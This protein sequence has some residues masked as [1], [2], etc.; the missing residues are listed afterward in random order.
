MT[1]ITLTNPEKKYDTMLSYFCEDYYH[2]PYDDIFSY[3]SMINKKAHILELEYNNNCDKSSSKI[4]KPHNIWSIRNVGSNLDNKNINNVEIRNSYKIIE[5]I[6]SCDKDKYIKLRNE[7]DEFY[8]YLYEDNYTENNKISSSEY[9]TNQI[10]SF[11]KYLVDNF[12]SSYRNEALYN[13]IHYDY[14][15]KVSHYNSLRKWKVHKYEKGCF[16]KPHKDTKINELHI[17][18]VVLI[19]PKNYSPYTGGNLII[20]DSKDQNKKILDITPIDGWQSVFIKLDQKHEILEVTSGTRYSFTSPFCISKVTVDNIS[21]IKYNNKIP[22]DIVLEQKK[23]S[24]EEEIEKNIKTLEDEIKKLTKKKEVLLCK[25]RDCDIDSEL[26][27]KGQITYQEIANKKRFMVICE[28]FYSNPQPD[29]LNTLDIDIYNS[30]FD[31]PE[32]IEGKPEVHFINTQFTLFSG[33]SDHYKGDC[34]SESEEFWG[35]E[36]GNS[37][38]SCEDNK[39]KFDKNMIHTHMFSELKKNKER[40]NYGQYDDTFCY[41]YSYKT[42]G[43]YVETESEYNDNYYENSNHYNVTC[44]IVEFI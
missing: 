1:S 28:G 5:H 42:P 22:Y 35:F 21:N 14:S 25:L 26:G 32:N 10:N 44:M 23:S 6:D 31:Y 39:L 34:E 16:F 43:R 4:I 17:G 37:Y 27:E 36:D 20:Y 12:G 7:N 9:L 29:K 15:G 13:F 19:P 3:S 8:V 33:N 41:Y 38:Y 11:N 24:I 2:N 40:R 30:I 18:T